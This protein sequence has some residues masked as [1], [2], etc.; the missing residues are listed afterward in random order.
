MS[1]EQ[2]RA[3]M[4]HRGWATSGGRSIGCARMPAEPPHATPTVSLSDQNPTN[5]T[6]AKKNYD[7]YTFYY[8]LQPYKKLRQSPIWWF[9]PKF[10][11]SRRSKLFDNSGNFLVNI[12]NIL[13]GSWRHRGNCP[14]AKLI[15]VS[16]FKKLYFISVLIKVVRGATGLAHWVSRP[17]VLSAV[18]LSVREGASMREHA[19]RSPVDSTNARSRV[20]RTEFIWELCFRLFKCWWPWGV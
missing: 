12:L 13:H 2:Q 11:N 6:D 1:V 17:S 10:V 9:A 4:S 20:Y 5:N 7:N 14:I 19:S 16:E 3:V 18:R 8:T 15:P